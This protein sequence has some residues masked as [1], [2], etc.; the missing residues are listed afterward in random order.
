[1][2]LTQA[3]QFEIE[4]AELFTSTGNTINITNSVLEVNIYEDIYSN[5]MYG[6]ISVVNTIGLISSGPLIGQEYLSIV[7]KTPTLVDDKTKIKFD[8]NIF[9]VIKVGRTIEGNGTEIVILDFT[10]SELIHNQRTLVSRTLK[11]PF[12]EIVGTLLRTD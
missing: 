7:L 3:G 12:H 9:H 6:E 11:G 10:T 2:E 8:E 5:S 1:M 4:S